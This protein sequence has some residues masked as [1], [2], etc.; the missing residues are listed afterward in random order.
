MELELHF[1][2]MGESGMYQQSV[3]GMWTKLIEGECDS[4]NTPIGWKDTLVPPEELPLEK[5]SLCQ[6]F[7]HI[8]N[9]RRYTLPS[10][11]D[12]CYTF[13]ITSILHRFV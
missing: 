12:I 8:W 3:G 13:V 5:R 11:T 2:T 6:L 1:I 10:T 9:D 4:P 7:W